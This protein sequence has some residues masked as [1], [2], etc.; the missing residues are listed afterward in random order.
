MNI[1]NLHKISKDDS[2]S[3]RSDVSISSEFDVSK[4][5]IV[6]VNQLAINLAREGFTKDLLLKF[7][8]LMLVLEQ[9]NEKFPS[10]YDDYE[11]FA[12]TVHELSKDSAYLQEC[13]ARIG[14]EREDVIATLQG[15]LH[16]LKDGSTVV[17]DPFSHN[18]Y[19]TNSLFA[20]FYDVIDDDLVSKNLS[21]LTVKSL[22]TSVL[23]SLGGNDR[24]SAMT[25]GAFAKIGLDIF[26]SEALNIS[27]F[28]KT[29][30]V[31]KGSFKSD[32]MLPFVN[33]TV[34]VSSAKIVNKVVMSAA[35]QDLTGFIPVEF[36]KQNTSTP[37]LVTYKRRVPV[38]TGDT[39]IEGEKT[40]FMPVKIAVTGFRGDDRTNDS[41]TKFPSSPLPEDPGEHGFTDESSPYFGAYKPGLWYDHA[42]SSVDGSAYADEDDVKVPEDAEVWSLLKA[43]SQ[44]SVGYK[45]I[46]MDYSSCQHDFFV[47]ERPPICVMDFG[48]MEKLYSKGRSAIKDY[49]VFMPC[50][51]ARKVL[52]IRKKL[53]DKNSGYFQSMSSRNPFGIHPLYMR[54]YPG[55]LKG[56]PI[57]ASLTYAALLAG[58]FLAGG[59]VSKI[60]RSDLLNVVKVRLREMRSSKTKPSEDLLEKVFRKI[61]DQ[62]F[63]LNLVVFMQGCKTTSQK[64]M[65]ALKYLH[66][67]SAGLS[68]YGEDDD[69]S[70]SNFEPVVMGLNIF[71]NPSNAQESVDDGDF[72]DDQDI[73]FDNGEVM[74][75]DENA[76][77]TT[78]DT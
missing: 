33:S 64:A 29:K 74:G 17:Y 21:R 10:A 46:R 45:F 59:N 3:S 70:S 11:R 54:V 37:S 1:K 61:C 4:V 68:G 24:M 43:G 19:T 51:C 35:I 44:V 2:S 55:M 5:N 75:S 78:Q 76:D 40:F 41:L 16:G 34:G 67:N 8:A 58:A 72:S 9:S 14:V 66:E 12:E 15:F 56:Y 47:S 26:Y 22:Y 71:I 60:D 73:N 39:F 53:L 23:C 48:S 32:V 38:Y 18:I 62:Q 57:A 27:S 28:L 63:Y 6:H 69:E 36:S 30:A 13:E 49:E 65:D 25:Q 7:R 50:G 52:L 20:R 77:Q 42:R 31:S